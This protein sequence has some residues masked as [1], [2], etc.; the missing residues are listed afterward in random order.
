[1]FET[2]IIAA[3]KL[4]NSCKAITLSSYKAVQIA[5]AIPE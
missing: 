2:Q 3:F 1:M 5:M 4:N